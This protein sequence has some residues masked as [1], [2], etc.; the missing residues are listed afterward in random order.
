MR[1][2]CVPGDKNRDIGALYMNVAI[3]LRDREEYDRALEYFH[4]ALKLYEAKYGEKHH[5]PA[6]IYNLIGS[7]HVS[8]DD[9][10]NAGVHFRKVLEIQELG[11]TS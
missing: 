6:G 2:Q 8:R 4:K 3:I 5:I 11:Y 1:P 9:L 10:E 7:I